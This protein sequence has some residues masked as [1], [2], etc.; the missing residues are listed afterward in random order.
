MYMK[1]PMMFGRPMKKVKEYPHFVLFV[2]EKL[3][4]RECYQY[5]DLTHEII[6]GKT[7]VYSKSGELIETSDQKVKIPYVDKPRPKNKIMN[8][9][10]LNRL[11]DGL[12]NDLM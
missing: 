8:D 5:W 7:F 11:I 2:D 4:I 12:F 10:R 3:G 6:N 1:T 9:T